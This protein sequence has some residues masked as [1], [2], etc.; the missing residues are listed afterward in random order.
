MKLV[1]A[2]RL[3]IFLVGAIGIQTSAE[4]T[5]AAAY[6]PCESLAG[7]TIPHAAIARVRCAAIR[8]SRNGAAA[9][10]RTKRRIS[11]ASTRNLVEP[12]AWPA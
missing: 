1:R 2:L 9:A 3:P 8:R 10:A 7:L 5:V 11:A 4:M 6:A 12:P